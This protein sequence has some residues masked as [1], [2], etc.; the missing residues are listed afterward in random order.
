PLDI[1]NPGLGGYITATPN[2]FNV[3]GGGSDIGGTTDEFQFA[4]QIRNGNFDV[5]VRVESI[6]Q[7]NAWSKAGLMA[8][9]SLNP[10]SVFAAVLTTP[11]IP[12]TF[13]ESRATTAGSAA[14]AGWLPVNHPY[15]WLR[16]QR[17]AATFSGF[18]SFDGQT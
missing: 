9:A 10:D 12:G 14:M 1:G 16:L 11:S 5:E 13:F 7:I 6:D 18:G 4:Y 17:I 2:G 8:R 15:T 3:V